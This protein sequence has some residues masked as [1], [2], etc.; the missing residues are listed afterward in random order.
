MKRVMV[1][2]KV[3]ADRA[4][5]NRQYIEKVFEELK[6]S[7]PDGLH[8]ASFKQSDGVSFV[9]IAS[10]DPAVGNPLSQSAA[11]KSFT[12]DIQDRCEEAPVQYELEEIGS[13][14]F[15]GN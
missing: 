2:Y 14:H 10:F 15:F 9:H 3:K 13:Y 5:E 12:A 6:Q 1:R 7:S 8:Y 4:E 11:F